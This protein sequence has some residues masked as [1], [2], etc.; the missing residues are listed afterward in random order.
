MRVPTASFTAVRISM[1]STAP[2]ARNTPKKSRE[3][4][5]PMAASG[6]TAASACVPSSGA[7]YGVAATASGIATT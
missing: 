7:T 2:M 3:L 5:A 1:P 4:R 6:V